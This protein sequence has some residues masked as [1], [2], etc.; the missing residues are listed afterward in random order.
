MTVL[1]TILSKKGAAGE[2]SAVQSNTGRQ[3]G[4]LC[5]DS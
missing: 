2:P 4:A 3:V 1:G 5:A